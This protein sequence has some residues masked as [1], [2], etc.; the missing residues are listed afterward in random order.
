VHACCIG[1][2]DKFNGVLYPAHRTHSLFHVFSHT[3]STAHSSSEDLQAHLLRSHNLLMCPLCLVHRKIFIG[4]Q[5]L[6]TPGQLQRHLTSRDQQG[7][8]HGHPICN[9]C[10]Q[11]FYDQVCQGMGER[12]VCGGKECVHV[13]LCMSRVCA[14]H[15]PVHA[16]ARV[17]VCTD[18]YMCI[19]VRMC[20]RMCMCLNARGRS[21][22]LPCFDSR[23]S[24]VI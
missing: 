13:C 6:Y 19:C 17:Y 7:P 22:S 14:V 3:S 1:L 9:M 8:Q 15:V 10:N 12:S 4:E 23:R 5:H 18:M 16:R 11:R 20:V 2:A 24:E 21:S